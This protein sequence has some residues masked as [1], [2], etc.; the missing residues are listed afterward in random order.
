MNF[1]PGSLFNVYKAKRLAGRDY[2]RSL[3]DEEKNIHNGRKNFIVD[4]IAAYIIISISAG[5]YLA[6]LLSFAGVP[7][8]YNGLILS[9]PVLSSFFQ[10]FGAIISKKIKSQ[11]KFVVLGIGFQRIALAMVFIYPLITGTGTLTIVLV[12]TTYAL[13]FFVGTAAGPAGGNWLISLVPKN[14]RGEFFSRREKFSLLGIAISTVFAGVVL[15]KSREAGYF[16]W[17]FAIIGVFLFSVAIIDIIHL[18]KI[19][20]VIATNSKSKIDFQSILEPL[21]D[22]TYI[23]VIII[24]VLWQMS[25]QI[26][27][28]FLGIYFIES[29]GME[30]TLIG[31]VTLAITFEKAIIVSKWGRFADRTSWDYV[32]KIA[33]LIYAFSKIL[34]VFLSPSNYIWL[35]PLSMI[36]GNIA[37]SVLG[38]SLINIQFQFANPENIVMYIGVSGSISGISG[39]A[40]ALLGARLLSV[41]REKNLIVN[42]NQFLL[43]LSSILALIL[44]FYIH[45]SMKHPD[46]VNPLKNLKNLKVK[47]IDMKQKIR[48]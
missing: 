17:G 1:K 26:A 24:L 11:K 23:K 34:L 46:M 30:Y 25:T 28:P 29:I 41:F 21:K 6:G 19:H 12:V 48:K 40:A 27:I 16:V 20:E 9:I 8:E 22:K 31:I 45:K 39:F 44:T 33:V 5:S 38:I 35:F 10:F 3:S 15:D 13:A 37:W 47:M 4:N 7:V 32:L 14:I 18:M 42:G 2:Y 43:I 36:I